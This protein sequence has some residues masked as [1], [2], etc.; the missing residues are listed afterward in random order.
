MPYALTEENLSLV[1][2]CV[3]LVNNAYNDS[4]VS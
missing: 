2:A 3:V 4:E 1:M